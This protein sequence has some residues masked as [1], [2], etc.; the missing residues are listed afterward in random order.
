MQSLEDMLAKRQPQEPPQVSALKE[1]ARQKFATEIHV[2]LNRNYYL[3]KVPNAALA[4][5]FR[6]NTKDIIEVCGLDKRL[7]IHIGY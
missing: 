7:V 3:I 1:Y 6:M 4:H 5:S 2:V